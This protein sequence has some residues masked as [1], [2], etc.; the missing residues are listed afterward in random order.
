MCRRFTLL[1]ILLAL[2]VALPGCGE[3]KKD[4]NLPTTPKQPRKMMKPAGEK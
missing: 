3:K 2:V 4:E 1:A